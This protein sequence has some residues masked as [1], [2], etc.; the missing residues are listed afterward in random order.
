MQLADRQNEAAAT[1]VLFRGLSGAAELVSCA[2]TPK[3]Q[4]RSCVLS[5]LDLSKHVA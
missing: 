2:Q 5:Y 4:C 1:H 3:V